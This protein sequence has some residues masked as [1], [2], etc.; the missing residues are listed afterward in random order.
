M[1]NYA[2]REFGQPRVKMQD[3]ED[4]PLEKNAPQRRMFC[5]KQKYPCMVGHCYAANERYGYY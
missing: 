4:I 3:T 5:I 1:Q 2:A